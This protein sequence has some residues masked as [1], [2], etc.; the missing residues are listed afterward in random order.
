[1]RGLTSI[2][3]LTLVLAGCGTA[4]NRFRVSGK[5]LHMNQGEFYVYSPDGGIDGMDTIRVEGGRLAY[6]IDCTAPTTL[7]VVFPNYSEQPIFAEPG[8][9]VE[10]RADVSHLKQLTVKGTR[11]NKLM[12]SFREEIENASPP[13]TQRLA[14]VFVKDHPESAVSAWL[15]R[16]YFIATPTPDYKRAAQLLA[17]MK[18][19]QPR[20]YALQRLERQVRP[21]SLMANGKPL[22]KFSARDVTGKT[23]GNQSLAGSEWALVNVWATWNYDSQSLQSFLRQTLKQ[24]KGRLRVVSICVD[25]DPKQCRERVE[26]D[27]LSWPTICDGDMLEGKTLRALGLYSVPDNILLHNGKVV[28]RGM[29]IR[30]LRKKL[31]QII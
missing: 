7:V 6:E 4:G 27:T 12:N 11:E 26:R 25:P 9:E 2:V 17:L 31:E 28:E 16:K 8:K 13:E 10:M 21:L 24:T 18:R 15:V 5:L 14:E 23:V 30:D 22:P 20:N 1:M 19:A 3:L 29:K